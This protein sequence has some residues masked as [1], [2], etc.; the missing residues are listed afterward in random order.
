MKSL[1]TP[2]E[3]VSKKTS[4]LILGFWLLLVIGSWGLYSTQETHLFPSIGQVLD[5]FYGLWAEGLVTHIFSSLWLCAKSVF[6]AVLVSL[7]LV[8]LSPIPLIKPLTTT[9][10]KFR[11]LPLT[12]IA[13]YITMMVSSGRSIQMWILVIFMTTFLVTTLLSMLKDIP[14][15][16]FDHARA[17]G[18]NRWVVLRE[19]VI[20]GRFDYVLDMVRQNIAIVWMFLV[21]VESLL[22]AAGGLGFLIKN[23]DKFMNHGRIIA[24]QIIILLIGLSL[25]FL[26]NK[27][28]QIS[29]RYSKL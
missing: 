10:S 28:R 6:F 9:I 13:F 19:V 23:S 18:C 14:E 29:F 11:F 22:A 20:K 2:F 21:T 24:L 25:D 7:I 8:Y 3:K 1:I 4:W 5:G 26:V 16:E 17:L 12:G 27:I 15:E